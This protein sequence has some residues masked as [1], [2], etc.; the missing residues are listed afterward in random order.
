MV[1]KV[2]SML[3]LLGVAL[4]LAACAELIYDQTEYLREDDC[5]RFTE[6][7]RSECLKAAREHFDDYESKRAKETNRGN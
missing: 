2:M 4:G 5:G 1:S 3:L 6:P 7:E